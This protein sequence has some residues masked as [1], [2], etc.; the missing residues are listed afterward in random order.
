MVRRGVTSAVPGG[1][2]LV[3]LLCTRHVFLIPATRDSEMY[4]AIFIARR[5]ARHSG[6]RTDVFADTGAGFAC[7]P[8]ICARPHAHY[9]RSYLCAWPVDMLHRRRPSRF[10]PIVRGVLTCPTSHIEVRFH[11]NFRNRKGL[12]SRVMR[13]FS[14]LIVL[15]FN[16][17]MW[18]QENTF[19]LTVFSLPV[20]N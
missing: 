20:D 16:T 3:T 7:I 4:R 19:R 17:V 10:D 2:G 12:E 11:I 15:L 6:P 5:A 18:S 13:F 14:L 1:T 9:L 8:T